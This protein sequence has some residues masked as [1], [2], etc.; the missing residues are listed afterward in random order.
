[1]HVPALGRTAKFG[2]IYDAKR[3]E[4]IGA[5]AFK[6]RLQSVHIDG[7][8]NPN[9]SYKFTFETRESDKM[10]ALDIRGELKLKIWCGLIEVGG[11]AKFIK[12]NLNT[13]KSIQ[14]SY[15]LKTTTKK[16]TINW[17]LSEL[18]N[19]FD[20]NG[21]GGG[22]HMV[23][24]I[25]YGGNGVVTLSYTSNEA[26]D[27]QEIKGSLEGKF[28]YFPSVGGD[29]NADGNLNNTELIKNSELDVN[30]EADVNFERGDNVTSLEGARH[31]MED[32]S[33]R[34]T[35]YN[36]GKG[37]QISFEL[38]PLKT[39]FDYFNIQ[40][41][42]DLIYKVLDN[43]IISKITQKLHEIEEVKEE[44][45]ERL[46]ELE[47][48]KKYFTKSEQEWWRNEKSKFESSVAT[49]QTEIDQILQLF[50]DKDPSANKRLEVESTRIADLKQ[51]VLIFISSS[52]K[53][54]VKSIFI[55]TAEE[56]NVTYISQESQLAKLK[57]GNKKLYVCFFSAH[58]YYTHYELLTNFIQ[59][60]NSNRGSPCS[61]TMIYILIDA[62]I[63]SNVVKQ[64]LKLNDLPKHPLYIYENNKYQEDPKTKPVSRKHNIAV[65]ID[66]GTTN[67]CVAVYGNNGVEV[68]ANHS[69]SKVTPSFVVFDG[70]EVVVGNEAKYAKPDKY[71]NRIYDTKRMIGKS[72]SDPALQKDK[73]T[74]PFKIV[75]DS[76]G[77]PKIHIENFKNEE[78]WFYPENISAFILRKMKEI[79]EQL[80]LGTGEEVTEAV[81]T[82]PAYFNDAQ[83]NA[84]K[85]AAEMAGLRVLRLL[86]EPSAAGL[87][88]SYHK[89]IFLERK[90]LV[91]DLGGGT[92][93]VS[94]MVINQGQIEVKAVAGDTHLGGN[95]FDQLLLEFCI[96]KFQQQT[97]QNI[98]DNPNAIRKLR[99]ASI[100]AKEHL[101]TSLKYEYDVENVQNGK[102]FEETITR[103]DFEYACEELFAKTFEIVDTALRDA[104]LSTLDIDEILLVGGSSRIPK[105]QQLLSDKFGYN[106]INKTINADEAVAYGAAIQAAI[107]NGE[108]ERQC[109]MVLMDVTPLSIGISVKDCDCNCA[110]SCA[111]ASSVII[112]RNFK[113]PTKKT[114]TY[115]TSY[116]NQESISID[117][118]EG[119]HH[120]A[121][122]NHSLGSFRIKGVPKN[123]RNMEKIDV[124]FE[125]D[126]NGSLLV[127]AKILSTGRQAGMTI[128]YE[129]KRLSQD[130]V[131][132]MLSYFN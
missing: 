4:F 40:I 116:D 60:S 31:F 44:L 62:D 103:K 97:R 75:P 95:D 8:E 92:F 81:I 56:Y 20:F 36:G 69:G 117:V 73:K 127:T 46:F 131:R 98:K 17:K 83:R 115:R 61:N 54:I 9:S 74:W 55:K 37:V 90:V 48:N 121:S 16:E 113:I 21:I 24:G 26:H 124:S 82:V 3:N 110:C 70:F 112:S 86:N 126:T 38:V 125:L 23:V 102:S 50:Q 53:L 11:S 80:Y 42:Q 129:K 6:E 28:K 2:D 58:N 84:T 19:H 51:N 33:T 96:E 27:C 132:K 41:S 12:N 101:S 87:A 67:S 128:N 71:K 47:C 10:E 25:Q 104:K 119:E 43:Q 123:K 106:K 65:G 49:T 108:I 64:E 100:I 14:C 88:F 72:F 76:Q 85:L 122:R 30:V 1:M 7:D 105:V 66:L 79:V 89:Q 13:K 34:L 118:I 77:R 52:D 114:S 5:N 57:L 29:I 91:Y 78:H 18:K 111:R 130:E 94:I 99:N 35:R 39:L 63:L 22:T 32:L 120:E 15:I 59:E 93:D 68:L 107:I 45:T 109:N